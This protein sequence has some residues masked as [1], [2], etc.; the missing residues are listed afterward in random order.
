MGWA[1]LNGVLATY[2]SPPG[3]SLYTTDWLLYGGIYGASLLIPAG[4]YTPI[5]PS[6]PDTFTVTLVSTPSWATEA[7]LMHSMQYQ[8]FPYATGT[9]A[10]PL[11]GTT[12]TGL[13]RPRSV[14]V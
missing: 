12:V 5:T 3:P 10:P 1:D 8:Y 13:A 4:T 7:G 9:V 14:A 6:N 11:P 2:P